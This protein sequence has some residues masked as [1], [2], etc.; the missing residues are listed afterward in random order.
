MLKLVRMTQKLKNDK[1]RDDSLLFQTAQL[2]Y[3]HQKRYEQ[4]SLAN[5][6]VQARDS[7]WC[8]KAGLAK[9]SSANQRKEHNEHVENSMLKMNVL[10]I[11]VHSVGPYSAA[12]SFV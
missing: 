5:A 10:K 12:M 2:S 11:N 1:N 9:K 8:T 6:K 7:S 3:Q 4:E